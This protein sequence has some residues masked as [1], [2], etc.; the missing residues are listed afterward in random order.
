MQSVVYL[1]AE[2][3][4]DSDIIESAS[5]A[6]ALVGSFLIDFLPLVCYAPRCEV[7]N[8]DTPH[9]NSINTRLERDMATIVPWHACHS[10]LGHFR[11]RELRLVPFRAGIDR[12]LVLRLADVVPVT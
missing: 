3:R 9:I 1:S 10:S 6:R 8:S 12:T 4:I 5:S 7:A 11:R 2:M